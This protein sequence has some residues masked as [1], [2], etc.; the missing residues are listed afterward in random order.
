MKN[1]IQFIV[2]EVIRPKVRP[3]TLLMTSTHP[4]TDS[5]LCNTGFEIYNLNIPNFPIKWPA[6]RPVPPNMHIIGDVSELPHRPD[7][8]LSQNVVDQLQIFQQLS[9][10]FDCPLISFEHTLPAPDWTQRGIVHQIRQDVHASAFIY[11]T[12]FS[13]R[14][15]LREDDPRA[16]TV[17]HMIDEDKYKGWTGGNGRAAMMV[18]S[19]MGRQWAVGDVSA[20]LAEDER[21][22]NRI[23]LF[24]NNPGFKS[25]PL[26]SEVDVVNTL[27]EFDVFINVS[28]ASPIPASLIEAA[29]IGMPILSTRTCAIPEFFEDNKNIMFFSSIGECFDLL[30]TL[31]ANKQL[32]KELG[33]EA[34]IVTQKHFNKTRYCQDWN[35]VVNFA[36]ENYHNE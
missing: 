2:D 35:K 6:N 33:A 19:F 16:F 13:K 21:R 30:E 7:I 26:N 29:S 15:W 23:S 11:I 18:N 31:L 12:D 24:G 5:N 36:L 9:Y 4:M 28:E 8:V 34:R 27:S 10:T 25:T 1:Q 3:I 32:R 22:N 17:Y 20:Y 14:A